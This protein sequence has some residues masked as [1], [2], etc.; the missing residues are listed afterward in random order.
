[1][2]LLAFGGVPYHFRVIDK[3]TIQ[4]IQ[5]K[6]GMNESD[7][8]NKGAAHKKPLEALE[9]TDHTV[10]Q[11]RTSQIILPAVLVVA[12]AV[13]VSAVHWPVLSAQ[14][15]APDDGQY[16]TE[17]PLVQ[18]PGWSSAFRFLTEVL[19]PSTVNGYYHPLAMISLMADYAIAGSADD[20]R[21]F[22]RTSLCLHVLNTVL[23][24]VLLTM[25]FRQVWVSAA[26][27][28]LFGVH[29]ITVDSLAWISDRKTLLATFFVL[30]CLVFY[31]RYSKKGSG[32]SYEACLLM[33]MLALLSKPT[34]T[35]LPI[36]LV[37]LDYWPL[38]RL[39]WR[40]LAEKVPFFVVGGISAVITFIS[41]A[42]TCGVTL[43][44]EHS[45]ATVLLVICH[46]IRFYLDKIIRPVNLSPNYAVPQPFALSNPAVSGGLVT[47]FVLI[48]VLL[49]SLRHT[50]ALLVG[51]LFF[52]VM[53]LPTMQIIGFGSMIAAN[54]FAYLPM[55]GLLLPLAWFA[56]TIWNSPTQEYWRGV[57]QVALIIFMGA[58]AIGEAVGARSYLS[59]WKN[60][61]TLYSHMLTVDPDAAR[62]RFGLAGALI[63]KGQVDE[64]VKLYREELAINP[65]D[66]KVLNNLAAAL[67]L[68][69]NIEE[70]TEHLIKAVQ[71][72]P[73]DFKT[74]NNLG[75]LLRR[76]GRFEEA[77]EQLR[78]A[79]RI[80]PHDANAHY[81]LGVLLSA[82]GHIDEAI[83]EYRMALE[84]NPDLSQ[85]RSALDAELE[86][87]ADESSMSQLK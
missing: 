73:D 46:S 51:F 79:V 36:L 67:I 21:P 64:A 87:K 30:S 82:R 29:P 14:A 5:W 20:L 85:A 61:E 35:P 39:N 66:Y 45:G 26:V 11:T 6:A 32:I 22:H 2:N 77:I 23:V 48:V 80:R 83:E 86:R 17:N 53:I 59:H 84:I 9:I 62:T 7:K 69:G 1:M 65:D 8:N 3:R 63:K 28:L 52:F 42:R 76:Q 16:L 24:I 70:A 78:H 60:T 12:V 13:A 41:H 15:L 58:L 38:G 71:L 44:A 25:L 18:K 34:S 56:S 72:R 4:T 74:R 68:A 31:V 37:L 43:P 55:V 75:L 54:R 27:G 19:K 81:S 50:R 47:A 33:Y 10:R 40:R 49:L 57:R